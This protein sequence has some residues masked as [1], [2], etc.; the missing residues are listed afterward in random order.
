MRGLSCRWYA[1]G[2]AAAQGLTGNTPLRARVI[3]LALGIPSLDGLSLL[4]TLTREG[5]TTRTRVIVI[6]A[7][8]GESEVVQALELGAFDYVPK[9]VSVPLLLQRIRRA[10]AP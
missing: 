3:L 5:V 7:R 2:A 1:D 6:S 4:R 8:S 10:L 9:P